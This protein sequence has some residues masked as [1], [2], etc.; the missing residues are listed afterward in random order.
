[1]GDDRFSAKELIKG[2]VTDDIRLDI[3]SLGELVN[4]TVEILELEIDKELSKIIEKATHDNIEN[5]FKRVDDF[6]DELLK[7]LSKRSKPLMRCS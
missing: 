5:R 6:L 7:R 2:E 3:Y 4:Y 1:M